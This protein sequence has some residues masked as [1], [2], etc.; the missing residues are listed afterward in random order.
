M[1]ALL[2][3]TSTAVELGRE[4]GR[5]SSG[6][7]TSSCAGR[8]P[9]S[10]RRPLGG[11]AVPGGEDRR[12]AAGGELARDLAAD[13]AVGPVMTAIIRATS[14]PRRATPRSAGVQLHPT[15]LPGGR[16]GPEARA[17]VD[18]LA[19]AGQTWWQM[20]PLGPPDRYGSPYKARS[21]VRRLA[22]AARER[23]ARRCRR[24]RSSTSA[25]AR[26][27]GS[28][29][30]CAS[31][32]AARVADQVRFDREWARAARVRR[33]ARRAADRRRADLRRAR[34]AP[35][36]ART[37]SCSSDGFVA[38]APPDAYTDKGQLW[39]NPLYD[40]PALRR[41]AATAGG[42]SGC[43]AR[44]TLFDLARID[45]F[46]GFVAYWAVPRGRAHARWRALEARAGARAVRRRDAREL[47]SLPRDRRG[48]RRHHPARCSGCATRSA[49]PGMV[50]LQFGFDPATRTAPHRLPTTPSTGR[51]HR[52]ARQRHAARLVRVAAD[53]RAAPRSTRALAPR[54]GG[55]RGVVGPDPADVRLAARAW[56]WCRRRTCSAWAR[57]ARMNQP[58]RAGGAWRWRHARRR[59]DAR[60]RRA[61]LRDAT[62]EAGRAARSRRCPERSAA[63]CR[64]DWKHVDKYPLTARDRARPSR[65][66]VVIGV[67]WYVEFDEPEQ[68]RAGPLLD[69]PRRRSSRK[70]RGGHCVCLKPTRHGD[71]DAWWDFYNQGAEGACVGFGISPPRLAAQPQALR[72]LLALPRGAED[73][74]VAGRGLRRHDRARRPGHP[75]QARPLRG[76]PTATTGPA[77]D[78]RGHQGQPLGAQRRRRP[79]DARLRRPGLR[80]R[81]QLV[82]PGGYP[83]LMRMPATV[84]ERL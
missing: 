30:G 55:R 80:R 42:S 68:G 8:A 82:G 44:S 50:V 34:A 31:P 45:H 57:E 38:G 71:P 24:P 78:R 3:R 40:W 65:R 25:S 56:R 58:G 72:R 60:A 35:T 76:R 16:L 59:A 10:L 77:D 64:R 27:P 37:P 7:V 69:R 1:A 75:A 61:A 29:T 52:H 53:E 43:G 36:T 70:V 5:R 28:R 66:P 39:G 79:A 17:F 18:W 84:L 13:P 22:R 12:V 49:C 47:G 21:R 26:R 62:E 81:P 54:A 46:R 33:R 15:S 9:T 23:R 74:R 63:S 83:H 48:P 4:R 11:G 2:T 32:G 51:L 73:R 67:N 14:L 20:L 19:A 41:R 6:S